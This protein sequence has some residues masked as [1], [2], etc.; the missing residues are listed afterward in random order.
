MAIRPMSKVVQHLRRGV[1]LR[2][3]AELTDG[4]LLECY[5]SDHEQAAFE[6]L[7]LRHGPMVWG[8]CCRVLSHHDDAEDAFQA[9]FLVLVRKAASVRPRGMVANWLYGVAYRTALKARA[10]AAKRRT[11]ERQVTQMPEP[12]VELDRWR[13]VQPLLDD[14]LS[15]LPDKYR[16]PVVLCDLEGK[17]YKEVARQLGCPEG[18]LSARLARARTMLARRL[19]RHGLVFSAGSLAVMLSQNAASACVPKALLSSTI[20]A[21]ALLGAGQAVVTGTISP[22]V[23]ALIEGTVKAMWWSK[24]KNTTAVLLA[25]A[26]LG[27]GT[28]VL[29][30][31]LAEPGKVAVSSPV[32]FVAAQVPFHTNQ[33][34]AGKKTEAERLLGTWRIA[35]GRVDGKDLP[36]DFVAVARLT[37]AKD[38]KAVMALFDEPKEG[39]YKLAGAGQIDL[40]LNGDKELSQGIYKFDGN[41]R[42]TLCV[43]ENAGDNR[44]AEFTGEQGT[45]QV[46]RVLDRAKP[47]EEKLKPE[48]IAK[49]KGE[50]EKVREAAARTVS[51]NNLKQIGV[52]MHIYHETNKR[53][54]LHAIYSK[55]GKTPLLSWRVAILPY[56]EE[57]ALYK[58]FKLDEPWDSE[59]N[60]KLIAKMPK[61]YQPAVQ[62][63]P[64]P[65]Q[66]Y[67]QVFTGP[68]TVFD[69]TKQLRL[70]DIGDGTSNTLLAIEAKEPVIWTKPAD[71][72]LPKEKNRMPSIGGLF[73]SGTFALLCDG[74]VNFLPR[75]LTGEQFRALV[76]PNGKD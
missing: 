65:G 36:V 57:L 47:G 67:Y 50:I 28:T 52:A 14:A 10:L 33:G 62:G 70:A 61:I 17:T 68:D 59:H 37:F 12:A 26:V 2:E 42:L 45:G 20:Q 24:L 22:K 15:R 55:D 7:V 71:L 69:G 73:K 34:G 56:I 5:V 41:D 40:A 3:R 31:A 19:R 1:L 43:K 35:S 48:E 30:H 44:P 58:E 13:E 9:T 11:R 27:F 8:V 21:V 4:Q 32:S 6:T 74:S 72:T 16:L 29:C 39:T 54:P 63:K 18:T 53:L 23:T 66:T 76:T 75:D 60:K 51:A 46:L 25:V 38:G 49:Y 64:G